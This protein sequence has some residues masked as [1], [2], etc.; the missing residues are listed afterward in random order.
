MTP[1]V[2]GSVAPVTIRFDEGLILQ[3]LVTET[4][5]IPE[6]LPKVTRI[7]LVPCPEFIVEPGG[8]DHI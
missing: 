5:T 8:T 3:P 7:E 6:L 1:G 4:L 2:K